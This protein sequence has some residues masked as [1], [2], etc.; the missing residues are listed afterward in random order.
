MVSNRSC[1]DEQD[2]S[3]G[4]IE[5]NPHNLDS[6]MPIDPSVL[7]QESGLKDS[8][9]ITEQVP[10]DP[11]FFEASESIREKPVSGVGQN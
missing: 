3:E 2:S 8:G 9:E 5:Q 1:D 11:P 7:Q 4:S 10:L 6:A